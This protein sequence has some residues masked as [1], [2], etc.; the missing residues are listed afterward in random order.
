MTDLEDLPPSVKFVYYILETEGPLTRCEIEQET[1]LCYDTTQYALKRLREEAGIVYIITD[2]S[3]PN[4]PKYS[5][6][7]SHGQNVYMSATC[8]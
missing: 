2:P 6:L 8:S 5:V 3:A 4:T 1:G 7:E